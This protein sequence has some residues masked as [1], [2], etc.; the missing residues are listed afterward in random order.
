MTPN[1]NQ[2]E[3]RL[4]LMTSILDCV[5]TLEVL[6]KSETGEAVLQTLNSPQS[7]IKTKLLPLLMLCQKLLLG[8]SLSEVEVEIIKEKV[9]E[10][11]K[12]LESML[13]RKANVS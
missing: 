13:E 5:G 4:F 3:V 1:L 2:N 7:P 6:S 10:D 9:K 12:L 8:L 11:L